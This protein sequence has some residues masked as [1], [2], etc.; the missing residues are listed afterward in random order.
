MNMRENIRLSLRWIGKRPLES[1]LL[2]LGIAL[3][4]GATSAGFSL[5]VH[6]QRETKELVESSRYREIVVT[7][8]EE[9]EEMEVSAV[10]VNS[11][12]YAILTDSDLNVRNEMEGVEYAYIANEGR[13]RLG[14]WGYGGGPGMGPEDGPP[15]EGGPPAEGGPSLPEEVLETDSPDPALEEIYGYQV[16]PEFFTA[17]GLVPAGGSLITDEDIEKDRPV[18]VL[19]SGL[20]KSLFKDGISL[21]REVYA[22]RQLYTIIG[23]LEPAG[24]EFDNLGFAPAR[25]PSQVLS[26]SE[27][28]R[29]YFS[30]NPV[31]LH[32]VIDNAE[33]LD[34]TKA[35][36]SSHFEDKYGE[37]ATFITL[38]REEAESVINRNERISII[39]LFLALSGLIIADVNVS[40]ILLGRMLRSRKK[41]GILKALGAA[42]A[43]IFSLFSVEGFFLSAGGALAGA[44]VSF[45]IFGAIQESLGLIS[46]FPLQLILGVLLAWLITMGLTIL[47][48]LQAAKVPAADAMRHE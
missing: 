14:A 34:E 32:F 21:G 10:P 25:I 43:N 40:N 47:P 15:V 22:R 1:F 30:R 17:Q 41:I 12:E 39:I 11:S 27:R 7:T 48:A 5:F 2:I 33:K 24:K 6:T 3:G 35:R 38:P 20:A 46:L 29:M 4:V 16:T 19:G 31:A 18:L 28:A 13:L 37:H 44:G 8:R 9:A 26:D 42:K 36:L 45:L 23:I